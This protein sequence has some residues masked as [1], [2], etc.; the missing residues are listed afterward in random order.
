M[1]LFWIVR[2]FSKKH[3]R[4]RYSD[5]MK[6]VLTTKFHRFEALL[7]SLLFRKNATRLRTLRLIQSIFFKEQTLTTMTA[8]MSFFM[9][10]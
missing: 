6:T 2:F 10:I 5:S 8:L 9:L 1:I 3:S 7:N 4:N